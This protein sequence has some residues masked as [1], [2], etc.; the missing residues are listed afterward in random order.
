MANLLHL[1]PLRPLRQIRRTKAGRR[2]VGKLFS[3]SEIVLL[4]V[5]LLLA[6]S[7]MTISWYNDVQKHVDFFFLK[8]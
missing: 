8:L 2:R 4:I 6:I 3:M 7:N 5:L 1:R